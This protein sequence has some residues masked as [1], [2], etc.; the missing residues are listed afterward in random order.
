M[1]PFEIHGALSVSG[2]KLIDKNGHETVLRGMSTHG[3]AWFPKF[4]NR[5]AF[6]TLRDIWGCN[7]V[8]AALYTHEYHGYCTDG[9]KEELYSLI[10]KAI[11]LARE[12]GL[13]IIVDWHVLGEQDPMLY[14]DEA[15]RFFSQLSREYADCG[16]ILYE[17]CNEPNGSADWPTI[18]RYA[19]MVIPAIRQHSPQAVIL[20]GTP[21]WCQRVDA[22]LSDPLECGNIMY[23]LH[24]Y[25]DSH[26]Q[27]IRDMALCALKAGLPV[28]VDEFNI[29]DAFGSGS[30]NYKEAAEWLKIIN[31]YGLSAVCW[32]LSSS[33]QTS[34]VIKNSCKKLSGWTRDDLSESGVWMYDN[35]FFANS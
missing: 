22:P 9:D 11:D 19:D 17:I 1:T 14:A 4:I 3:V 26:R 35:I 30:I 27:D 31:T 6:V 25:A 10:K 34:S 13:Y 32:S 8:R 7:C 33:K 23:S 18:K 29:T 24:F 16:N 15:V 21:D 20:V 5:E 12:L 2:Q 28:F